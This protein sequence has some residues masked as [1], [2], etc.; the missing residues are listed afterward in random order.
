M[1]V[2]EGSVIAALIWVVSALI[3]WMFMLPS[4]AKMVAKTFN[5]IIA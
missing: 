2:Q 3:T 4:G 1:E 5:I